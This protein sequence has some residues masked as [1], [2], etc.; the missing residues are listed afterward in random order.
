MVLQKKS[1]YSPDKGE[2]LD[3]TRLTESA[4]YVPAKVRIEE[5][6]VAG[7]RL[8]DY[9]RGKYDFPPDSNVPED[10]QEA[11]VDVLRTPGLDMADVSQMAQQVADKL[12]VQAKDAI[13][14]RK[15]EDEAKKSAGK[16][17]SDG[18]DPD[19]EKD[20]KVEPDHGV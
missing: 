9:R 18:R 14:K 2:V 19:V 20:E 16:K 8:V 15:I 17:R 4:G 3:G 6:I 11:Y 13:E 12:E 5:M 7:E 1:K 10:E